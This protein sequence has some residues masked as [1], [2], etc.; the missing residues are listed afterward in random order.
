MKIS[1]QWIK[2]WVDLNQDTDKTVS[3]LT[4]LGLEVDEVLPAA[5]D[6]SGV[7]VAEIT[8]CQP[9]PNADKLQICA[10]NDGHSTLQIVCGAPNARTGIKVPL[11][12]VGAVLP[13][14]FKIK[15]SKLRGEERSEER[16][17]GKECVP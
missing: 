8:D 14:D 4:M 17:V 6:F 7:V 11:A 13:G 2:Q 10:V 5:G 3:Q 15:K 1:E 12:Q 9:H 16:R